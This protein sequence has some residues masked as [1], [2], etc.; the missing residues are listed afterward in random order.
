[1]SS[2]PGYIDLV[3]VNGAFYPVDEVHDKCHKAVPA[4]V[5]EL[6]GVP[7]NN[8]DIVAKVEPVYLTG[9]IFKFGAAGF[10]I[11]S[12]TCEGAVMISLDDGNRYTDDFVPLSELGKSHRSGS[13][14]HATRSQI[15][16]VFG[17]SE[18]KY[19]G[20]SKEFIKLIAKDAK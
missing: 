16:Q 4:D 7:Y 20:S 1:M 9:S 19:V 11:L 14:Y 5:T 8:S 12:Y 17:H 6:D 15:S 3:E 10:Y 13:V 18:W 2:I